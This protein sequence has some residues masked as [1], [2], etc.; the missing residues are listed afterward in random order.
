MDTQGFLAAVLPRQGQRFVVGIRNGRAAQQAAADDAAV[1]ERA[2]WLDAQGFDVYVAIG[3]YGPQGQRLAEN[4]LWHR[5]L[6]LDLDVAYDGA[7]PGKYGSKR[8]ALQA[9][10]DFLDATGLPR[11]LI[12]DSGGGWHVYWPF[13]CDVSLPTW[14]DMANRLK[15]LCLVRGLLADPTVTA[16]AARILRV[17]GTT[18]TKPH[19]NG[20]KVHVAGS[21]AGATD[22][23]ALSALLPAAQA[24]SGGVPAAMQAPRVARQQ[25]ALQMPQ[26][27]AYSI[28]E[29]I[30]ECGVLTDMLATKGNGYDN[31]QWYYM[32]N[33]VQASMHTAEQKRAIALELSRGWEKNGQVFDVNDFERVFRRTTNGHPYSCA[34][35]A[36]TGGRATAI[37][38]Q[39]P[40]YTDSLPS[41]GLLGY[42]GFQSKRR[43]PA[44][45]PAA[46]Q[47]AAAAFTGAAS[48]AAPPPTAG[49]QFQPNGS[50]TVSPMVLEYGKF[51]INSRNQPCA[52]VVVKSKEKDT[53]PTVFE[54]PL[55]PYRLLSVIRTA[56]QD[57]FT[58]DAG[59][60][61]HKALVLPAMARS[62]PQAVHAAFSSAQLY[63]DST[64]AKA[65]EGFMTT[66][67]Q[68]LQT[69]R[70][71][72]S[73]Q[74]SSGWTADR[75]GF[76]LGPTLYTGT[77][78]E[79]NHAPADS[80][81][82]HYV[83][84]GDEAL[85]RRSFDT[86]LHSGPERQLLLSLGIA[87]PLFA[88]TDLDG[89]LVNLHSESGTGKTTTT[90]ALQS[91]W[92]NPRR[93]RIGSNDTDNARNKLLG[94]YGTMPAV[95]DEDT[96]RSGEALL[97]HVL[98]ITNGKERHRLGISAKLNA[99]VAEWQ[100]MV[101]SSS[102]RS[103]VDRLL[104]ND[105]TDTGGL[106][107]V[108]E[109]TLPTP[110]HE[111]SYTEDKHAIDAA[112]GSYGFLGP[113][114]AQAYAS[115][116]AEKLR[117]MVHA[118]ILRWTNELGNSSEDRFRIAV[119]A[120]AEIGAAFGRGVCGLDID[121]EGVRTAARACLGAMQRAV[122]E[123]RVTGLDFVRDFVVARGADFI[124]YHPGSMGI[125]SGNTTRAP[126]G[127]RHHSGNGS[128]MI[129]IRERELRDYV[130]NNRGQWAG[131][132]RQ[133]ATHPGVVRETRLFG[134]STKG[135]TPV[136]AACLVF[137][138]SLIGNTPNLTVVTNAE[139]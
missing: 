100:L 35:M 33:T 105:A 45:A 133:V 85:W 58:F 117:E 114:L 83:P 62:S 37:C 136:T 134:S 39:C 79:S 64:S 43:P 29:V 115:I 57:T 46:P 86:I 10:A 82:Q 5:C 131:V 120:L 30:A 108:F 70:K 138:A 124:D 60:D 129:V 135:V 63:V 78:T 55:I 69:A 1:E 110:H 103:F 3:G 91:I 14:Q 21:G 66:F 132:R 139:A 137:R 52:H 17:P 89:V 34:T 31:A 80:L 104:L 26:G 102:N 51:S 40:Y 13:T 109:I 20:P 107:R 75:S 22:P 44:G 41:V 81:S 8:E 127:E 118:S 65:M 96:Q 126:M 122:S 4:A 36:A 56:Q 7:K 15:N 50:V 32:L 125:M 18:N 119:A 99:D 6:R 19:L 24:L 97:S 67:L 71:S 38:Q 76:V 54:R 77:G 9:L 90:N 88:L 92:G 28:R 128:V 123:Q 73:G 87:A 2:S 16:D 12:V 53:A 95:I 111:S 116:G 98:S 74:S 61:G 84:A 49:F 59:A 25:S 130:Q 72:A 113:R 23:T 106:A 47:Q 112:A 48:V 11:P 94:E 93:L 101:F 68:R 121:V 42:N 27:Q